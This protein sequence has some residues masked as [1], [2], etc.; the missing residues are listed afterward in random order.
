MG[1]YNGNKLA[2]ENLLDVARYCAMA[3]VKAPQ[4]TGKVNIL[5]EIITEEDIDPLEEILGIQ[6]KTS[7]VAEGD[8]NT[9]K[10]CREEG[11]RP[12]ILLVGASNLCHCELEWD[13]GACGFSTCEEFNKYSDEVKAE[14]NKLRRR[15]HLGPQC[16]WKQLDLG[17]AMCWAS[18]A[19]AEFNVENR[20]IASIWNVAKLVGYMEQAESGAAL[21]LG[22][23]ENLIYYDRPSLRGK[24]TAQEHMEFLFRAMPSHFMGFTGAR[25][26]RFKYGDEWEKKPKRV[27]IAPRSE[28]YFAEI[29]EDENKIDQI[30]AR[31]KAGLKAKREGKK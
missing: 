3:A 12:V 24:W 30:C 15:Y 23:I 22:P 29:A 21:C 1:I 20:M 6:A 14:V 31:V 25:D 28:E 9:L 27:H 5:T 7:I 17:S 26:P 2:Q 8:Y 13:C 4:I 16:S 18:A 10:Y 19:A 11:L